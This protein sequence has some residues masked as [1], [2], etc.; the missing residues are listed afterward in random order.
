MK[1][2]EWIGEQNF[3]ETVRR[4]MLYSIDLHWQ[5]HLESMDYA[6]SSTSLRAY[7]QREPLVEYKR[8]FTAI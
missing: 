1:R 4:I 2:K 6:R 8:R 7:G 3:Y 5:E